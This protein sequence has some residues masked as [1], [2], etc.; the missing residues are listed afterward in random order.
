MADGGTAV[1][2]N[3]QLMNVQVLDCNKNGDVT[4]GYVTS[5][6]Q[7]RVSLD[8]FFSACSVAWEVNARSEHLLQ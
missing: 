8:D 3:C 4:S 5:Y 6:Q 2:R 7:V 1:E